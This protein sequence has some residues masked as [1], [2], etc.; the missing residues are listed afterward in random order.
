MQKRSQ[1][2]PFATGDQACTGPSRDKMLQAAVIKVM[3]ETLED[4]EQML[5]VTVCRL[6]GGVRGRIQLGPVGA[7]LNYCA[8]MLTDRRVVLRRY[9]MA[10]GSAIRGRDLHEF[11][12]NT[13]SAME[14]EDIETFGSDVS[15]RVV[16]RLTNDSSCR[17]RVRGS[18]RCVAAA[19]ICRV[20]AAI[21]PTSMPPVTRRRCYKC[22]QG[23]DGDLRF[24]PYCGT[25][26]KHDD[27]EPGSMLTIEGTRDAS[28]YFLPIP[29][30]ELPHS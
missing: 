27:E 8:F 23:L 18:W 22:S 10:P 12:I 13:I 11:S 21:A 30:N 16:M 4:G 15:C 7:S 17:F 26:L 9:P 29:D 6:A 14:F 5:G 19:D 25:R 2:K 1:S 20:F 28:A 24:C 3:Q